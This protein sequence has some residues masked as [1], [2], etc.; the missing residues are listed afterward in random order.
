VPIL[1]GNLPVITTDSYQNHYNGSV[2]ITATVISVGGQG[3]TER[4]VV[5]SESP[6][7][8]TN[9]NKE[10]DG[11]TTAGTF[12]VNFS[13]LPYNTLCYFRAYATNGNGTAYG[14]Q[15]SFTPFVPC[16]AKG[17]KIMLSDGSQK[18][19]EDIVYEDELLVWNFDNGLFDSAKPLWIGLPSR[20]SFH[21]R[22][23]FS[24]GTVLESVIPHLGH[25][26]LNIEDGRFAYPMSECE[27][28]TT[29]FKE[30]GTK[31]SI[32][33][34]ELVFEEN[35]FYNIITDRHINL[36]ANGI[37]TSCR[38]NNIYPIRDMRFVK[39]GRPMRPISEFDGLDERYYHGLRAAEQLCDASDLVNYMAIRETYKK[40]EL[41]GSLS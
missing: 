3:L 41:E 31:P 37:L 36:F 15:I 6:N 5:W 39:D 18:N 1:D 9:D 32:V 12:T 35:S 7:P 8:T 19:I 11:Q 28:G 26:V 16:L 33:K 25:R 21:N 13:G 27:A 17:T 2:D 20:S 22:I 40:P 24:D 38:W 10:V 14:N 4:G 23:T 29:T 30:D 34:T